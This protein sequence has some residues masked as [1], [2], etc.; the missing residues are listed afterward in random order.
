[1][2]PRP[3][4]K[5]RKGPRQQSLQLIKNDSGTVVPT[6]QLEVTRDPA[7]NM[8]VEFPD[9]ARADYLV[10][11]NKEHFPRLWKKTKIITPRESISHTAPHLIK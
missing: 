5:I 4:L 8:F 7:D 10:A 6:R 11:G 9:I 1:V 3:E 2:L